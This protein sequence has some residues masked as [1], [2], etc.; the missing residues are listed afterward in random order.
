MVSVNRS[1]AILDE[2]PELPDPRHP[3]LIARV[4]GHLSFR[5]VGFS[6]TNSRTALDRVSFEIPA[7]ARVGVIGPSGSGKSSLINLIARFYDPDCGQILLDG[8]DLRDYRLTDLRR[9]LAIVLQD[10]IVFSATV[11][12]NIA[13]G[14][15]SAGREE[16]IEAA[17]R[18]RAHDFITALPQGYDTKIG[19]GECRLSGGERQRLGIARASLKNAPVMIMDEPTSAVDVDTEDEIM[20]AM[21][22]LAEGR[23]TLVIAHRLRTLRECDLFLALHQGSLMTITSNFDEAVQAF[24]RADCIQSLM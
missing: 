19:D 20:T 4:E 16:V 11:A 13:Y 7:G 1:L 10:T 12:E 9:Q 23:T 5:N 21:R 17:R 18:A 6:Y 2:V 24:S 14:D 3:V 15:P 22:R 8:R